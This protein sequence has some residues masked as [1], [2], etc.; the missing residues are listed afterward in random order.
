MMIRNAKI[1]YISFLLFIYSYVHTLF[2]PSLPSASHPSLSPQPTSLPG[3]TYS[4]LFSNFVEE[5]T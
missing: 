1:L 4:A 3:R 2:D 5:K